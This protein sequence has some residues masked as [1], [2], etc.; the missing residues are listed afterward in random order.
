MKV[1]NKI[2]IFIVIFSSSC[3]FVKAQDTTVGRYYRWRISAGISIPFDY[4]KLYIMPEQDTPFPL[5]KDEDLLGYSL[6]FAREFNFH[7]P[8]FFI[9]TGVGIVDFRSVVFSDSMLYVNTTF[10]SYPLKTKRELFQ[11]IFVYPFINA[12][13]LLNDKIN[14]FVG[15][16]KLFGFFQYSDRSNWNGDKIKYFGPTYSGFFEFNA[17]FS[18]NLFKGMAISV[19]IQSDDYFS[20]PDSFNMKLKLDYNFNKK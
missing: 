16:E 8:N 2:I 10:W 13:Y 12:Y 7:K 5:Y 6:E 19:E 17:G 9:N 20:I 4:S 3:L 14:L 11:N 1:K 15:V 18:F